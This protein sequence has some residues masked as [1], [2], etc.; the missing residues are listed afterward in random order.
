MSKANQT[1]QSK[2]TNNFT[3]QENSKESNQND[4]NENF[5]VGPAYQVKAKKT[6]EKKLTN[7]TGAIKTHENAKNNNQIDNI[8]SGFSNKPNLNMNNMQNKIKPSVMDNA[9]NAINAININFQEGKSNSN[10]VS[11]EQ[12]KKEQG[13][14]ENNEIDF[15]YLYSLVNKGNEKDMVQEYIEQ[16]NEKSEILKEVKIEVRESENKPIH[17]KPSKFL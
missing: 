7:S 3:T 12:P 16:F 11:N 10:N 14:T 5:V 6:E 17:K 15:E 9:F 1:S 2:Q 4:Q 13:E 8:F